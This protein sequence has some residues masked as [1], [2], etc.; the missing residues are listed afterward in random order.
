M[1][2]LETDLID[3]TAE[4]EL[5]LAMPRPD[6]S[7]THALLQAIAEQLPG[8]SVDWDQDAGESWGQVIWNQK[9]AALV[10]ADLAIIFLTSEASVRCA[11]L[12][13][14]NARIITVEDMHERRYKINP[15]VVRKWQ[16]SRESDAL[17]PEC[18]SIAEFWFATV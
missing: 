16:P 15:E 7:K 11:A 17:H 2:A 8:A 14:S 9:T 18:F 1:G 5:A 10:A 12:A 3:I 13:R 6:E 4:L